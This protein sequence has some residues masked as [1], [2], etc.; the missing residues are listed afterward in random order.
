MLMNLFLA[1]VQIIF[2][3]F[4]VYGLCVFVRSLADAY[5]IAK[6][7][8]VCSIVIKKCG[9]NAEY[10]VR[11]AESRFVFG[12]YGGFFDEIVLADGVSVSADELE[13]LR[14]EFENISID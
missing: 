2:G 9:E 13:R 8:A 6:S 11:F 4:A 10:A 5:V 14:K 1:A 7:G 12:D 3:I